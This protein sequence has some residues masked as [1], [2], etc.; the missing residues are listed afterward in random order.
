MPFYDKLSHFLAMDRA[1][2]TLHT[3]G[4]T[5]GQWKELLAG[6]PTGGGGSG[7][8]QD[9]RTARC[10]GKGLWGPQG[11]RSADGNGPKEPAPFLLVPASLQDVGAKFNL[12]LE[13]SILDIFLCMVESRDHGMQDQGESSN[14]VEIK[15]DPG[16]QACTFHLVEVSSPQPW[17]LTLWTV[18]EHVGPRTPFPTQP[19]WLFHSSD[20]LLPPF[21]M[22]RAP[23]SLPITSAVTTDAAWPTG[24][25]VSP[26]HTYNDESGTNQGTRDSTFCPA[27]CSCDGEPGNGGK[28]EA[29][30]D[31]KV[32]VGDPQSLQDIPVVTALFQSV[33]VEKP[34]RFLWGTVKGWRGVGEG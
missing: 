2:R 21:Q 28:P 29:P 4:T 34:R 14:N 22:P 7:R 20:T 19:P 30:G 1:V 15:I 32:R 12:K 18:T 27:S 24:L 3:N 17:T 33:V 23:P 6:T 5:G 25:T 31:K 13:L 9:D 26:P 16:V 11:K 8:S 10:P